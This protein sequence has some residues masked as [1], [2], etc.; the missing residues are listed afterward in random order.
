MYL[1]LDEAGTHDCRYLVIAGALSQNY[2]PLYNKI[3]N[4]SLNIKKTNSHFMDSQ[5]VKSYQF[6]IKK[7]FVQGILTVED[8]NII[9]IV[10]D[11]IWVYERLRENQNV[12]INYL[13]GI[14][15]L[16]IAKQI[17]ETEH[18]YIW[19]DSRSVKTGA[20]CMDE[21]LATKIYGDWNCKFSFSLD[22]QESHHSFSIQG[23]HY[24]SNAIWMKYEREKTDL[25][26]I[27][28]PKINC[29][30]HFPNANFGKEPASLQIASS[31]L[32]YKRDR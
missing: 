1:I 31:M 22:Y 7:K 25:Y 11:K 6:P 26:D 28:R 2:K 27:L 24:I 19:F 3:K 21:Y 5:E 17:S 32:K 16:P 30:K 13:M 4:I 10:A 8:L 15:L 9:Y 20:L 23:A 18:L 12:F 29:I 14:L